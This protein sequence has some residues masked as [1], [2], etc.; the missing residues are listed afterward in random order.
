MFGLFFDV[1]YALWEFE[2]GHLN[3][4]Q[5]DF[6]VQGLYYDPNYG[7]NWWNYYSE[8]IVLGKVKGETLEKEYGN[9]LHKPLINDQLKN[10]CKLNILVIEA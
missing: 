3:S 7:S 6:G 9:M 5:L 2:N 8:P 4:L 1:L 10:I